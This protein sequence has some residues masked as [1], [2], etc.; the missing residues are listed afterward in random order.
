MLSSL[1]QTQ[2]EN[3]Q[4]KNRILA[5]FSNKEKYWTIKEN[6]WT[7]FSSPFYPSKFR[8]S[9][10]KFSRCDNKFLFVIVELFLL[11]TPLHG[12]YHKFLLRIKYLFVRWDNRQTINSLHT[13]TFSTFY[14]ALLLFHIVLKSSLILSWSEKNKC[15]KCN[16]YYIVCAWKFGF[17]VIFVF[18][19]NLRKLGQ[20]I[21]KYGIF[22]NDLLECPGG[23]WRKMYGF[24]FFG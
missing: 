10:K 4:T 9:V 6:S 3:F 11:N 16:K 15:Q 18:V 24:Q 8:K 2:S 1:Q 23:F 7:F 21:I 22:V 20:L 14:I 12:S 19:V 17:V 5:I 13:P